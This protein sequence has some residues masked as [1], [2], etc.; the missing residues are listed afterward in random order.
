MR[1]RARR[2]DFACM[3]AKTEGGRLYT[4]LLFARDVE[5]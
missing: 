2:R 3:N 1:I 4:E 5:F